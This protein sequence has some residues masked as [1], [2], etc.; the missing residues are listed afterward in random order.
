MIQSGIRLK[1]KESLCGVSQPGWLGMLHFGSRALASTLILH[2]PIN[3][4]QS[5]WFNIGLVWAID[6]QEAAEL[7]IQDRIGMDDRST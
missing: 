1:E 4:V 5:H 3:I 6:Q 7:L 2:G